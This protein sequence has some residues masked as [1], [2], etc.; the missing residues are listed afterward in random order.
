M[1]K[2]RR[3][4]Y[5]VFCGCELSKGPY[6]GVLYCGDKHAKRQ[7]F[8]IKRLYDTSPFEL[9]RELGHEALRQA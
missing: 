2:R 3:R 4:R 6:R 9:Q 8:A 5:C 1:P 7:V